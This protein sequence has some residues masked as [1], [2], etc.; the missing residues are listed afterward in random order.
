MDEKKQAVFAD[1]LTQILNHGALNL[2]LALGYQLKIFDVMADLGTPVSC[3]DL[4]LASKLHQR[5][6]QEWLG[7]MCTGKIIEVRR[8]G[9]KETTYFLPSEHAVLLTGKDGNGNMGVYTQEIPLLTQIAMAHVL[10]D[11]SKGEGIPFS[12]YPRFQ[13]FMAQ[14]SHARHR[15]VLVN[16]FLPQ[17][18]DGRLMA[19]LDQGIR[20]CD[21]GCGQGVALQL[22]AGQFP[23]ASFTGIDNDEPAIAQARNQ[24]AELGLENTIFLVKDAATVHTDQKFFQKFDYIT[25]FDAI[26]DQSHPLATLKGVRHMLAP[27]GMFSMIDIDADSHPAGNMDHPMGP[28]LYTVSLMHCMPVGLSDQGRGLGMMWGRDQAVAL[29]TE[30]GF[31]NI[32]VL[33]MD[34]DPFNVHYL[35]RV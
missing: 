34:H 5:Y 19:R 4:A 7:I 2:A 29:L 30:A 10:E 33:E 24:A 27:G 25:A 31:E 9:E 35:C 13:Q 28:F 8:D 11:F 26:H 15:Q 14:L 18:D 22:M 23:A 3:K 12:A 32:Q 6:V 20:V 17:V 1:K 16:H 21:L